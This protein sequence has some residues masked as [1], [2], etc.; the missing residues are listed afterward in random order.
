M[1]QQMSP[2]I[3]WGCASPQSHGKIPCVFLLGGKA[4]VVGAV[5]GF[6][7]RSTFLFGFMYETASTL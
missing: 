6:A 2:H 4:F 1:P 5:V 7:S 3:L